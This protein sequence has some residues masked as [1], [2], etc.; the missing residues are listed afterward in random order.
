MAPTPN[1]GDFSDFVQSF[2]SEVDFSKNNCG[3]PFTPFRAD[4][5]KTFFLNCTECGTQIAT[6]P[7][8]CY[9]LKIHNFYPISL[10]LSQNDQLMR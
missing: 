1:F 2:L 3:R 9:Y 4:G 10:R 8:L 7:E 5:I 6:C